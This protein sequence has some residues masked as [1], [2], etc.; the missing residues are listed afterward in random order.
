MRLFIAIPMSHRIRSELI[1]VQMQMKKLGYQGN[2]TRKENLH[3]TLAFLGE[4]DDPE[5]ILEVIK[6][7]TLPEITLTFSGIGNFGDI[8]WLGVE[9]NDAL[10]QYVCELRNELKEHSICFDEKAFKAH[11]TLSRNTKCPKVKTVR[12]SKLSMPV[13]RIVLMCSERDKE[14][15]LIY[16]EMGEVSKP[17]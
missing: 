7:V 10:N 17:Q 15:T 4:R 1:G 5:H 9:Q 8:I 2:F 3:M 12:F 6:V 14:G 16:R 13:E 11:I